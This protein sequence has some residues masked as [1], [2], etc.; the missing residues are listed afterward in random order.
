MRYES[1]FPLLVWIPGA[2][3]SVSV[4]HFGKKSKLSVDHSFFSSIVWWQI[5]SFI[6]K[7]FIFYLFSDKIQQNNI[8]F[9]FSFSS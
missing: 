2:I 1:F 9:S 4:I 8:L 7:I 5:L 6:H 3:A